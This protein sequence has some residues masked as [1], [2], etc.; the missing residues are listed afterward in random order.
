MDSAVEMFG[1]LIF[2]WGAGIILI[3]VFGSF[4]RVRS[5]TRHVADALTGAVFCLLASTV[6]FGEISATARYVLVA[7]AVLSG[8]LSWLLGR[9]SRRVDRAARRAVRT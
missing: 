1:W 3:A 8:L 6:I 7:A 2:A 5:P 9:H 4:R